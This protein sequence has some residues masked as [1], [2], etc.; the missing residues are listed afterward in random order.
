MKSQSI[1]ICHSLVA[2]NVK[3]FKKYFLTISSSEN[4]LFC[5]VAHILVLGGLIPWSFALFA[6]AKPWNS[7][8]CPPN[9]E[10][11]MKC[12]TCNGLLFTYKEK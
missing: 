2:K 1:L 11:I 10:Q 9:E 6:A 8:V 3:N 12:G 7:T 5:S 4:P